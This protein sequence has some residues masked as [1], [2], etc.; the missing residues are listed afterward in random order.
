MGSSI[1]RRE[2]ERQ[3]AAAGLMDLEP[4]LSGEE[5][6]EPNLSIFRRV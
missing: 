6:R 1:G 5:K 4:E 3:D 2:I